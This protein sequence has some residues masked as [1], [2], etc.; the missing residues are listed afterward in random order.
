M[1]K[2]QSLIFLAVIMLLM[3]CRVY[4]SGIVQSEQNVRVE[5]PNGIV[6]LSV[7]DDG[8]IRTQVFKGDELESRWNPAVIA[9]PLPLSQF[10][11]KESEKEVI[12][13]TKK[14]KV[15]VNKE[16]S[17]I[18]YYN[19]KGDLLTQTPT[20]G[21][22]T[23]EQD[24]DGGVSQQFLV[25][26][27]E[28]LYGVGQYVNGLPY[29]NGT[30]CTLVQ[31]NMEDAGHVIMSDRGYGMFWNNP[32]AGEFE[33]FGNHELL[34][35]KY[36]KTEDGQPGFQAYF[37]PEDSKYKTDHQGKMVKTK[38]SKTIDVSADNSIINVMKSD[39]DEIARSADNVKGENKK[40]ATLL[41]KGTLTTPDRT[42][43]YYFNIGNS[44]RGVRFVVDG[45]RVVE[46]RI[47]HGY[48]WN[49]GR[50]WLEANTEYPFELYYSHFS[51][52]IS[53]QLYWDP[54]ADIYKQY[55]WKSD[56]WK[57]VDYF[58]FADDDYSGIMNK[59]YA[60]T[61]KPSIIPKWSL[62]YIHCQAIPFWTDHVNGFKREGFLSLAKYYRE[63]Q[64]PCDV[65]VQDFMWWT[66]MGSH[67]FRPDCYPD[68]KSR[69]KE[70]HDQ[71]F[72]YMISV[73]PL[74]QASPGSG[75]QEELTEA[76]LK[77]R[78]ELI[79]KGLMIGDS[80]VNYVKKEARE[81]AWRQ[82]EE[83]LYN[84]DLRVDAFWLD[85]DEGGAKDP[86]Y[87]NAYPLLSK[88]S[89]HDG[90]KAAYPDTRTFLMGRSMFPG[91]QRYDMAMWSGDIGNDFWTIE[92]QISA[93]LSVSVCGIPYWTTDIGGFGGGFKRD[94][95]YA[96]GKDDATDP[97]FREVV[98][99]WFQYG[100]FCPIFRLHRADNNAAPWFYG[101]EVEGIIANT[102]RFRYRLM[103][104][105]YSMTKRTR[106]EGY[107]PMRPL[108]M[109]FGED[110]NIRDI[111]KQFMYG[112]AFLVCP[113]TK[114]LYNPYHPDSTKKEEL[115]KTELQ[116]WDLYLPKG[117]DWYDFKTGEKFEG[118]QTISAPAPLDWM[119][120]YVKAGS[121]VPMGKVIQ[122]TTSEKQTE[123]E[124]R[125][126]PGK[127]VD[128]V[129]YD[130]D[131]VSYQYE[132]GAYSEIAIHWNDSKQEL[133][134][135]DRKGSYEGM[136]EK[137]ILKPVIV[138]KDYGT[139]SLAE[140]D[141]DIQIEYTGKSVSWKK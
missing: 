73:W 106:E 23:I 75:Y 9:E 88:M 78:N 130:D 136:P 132:K 12:L 35:D 135:G 39:F 112:D 50:K 4:A 42:G 30:G 31:T 133:T 69:L 8:I 85:A 17:Q 113:V 20:N 52:N 134:I 40:G 128:Y 105:V 139:G 116:Y 51:E 124:L 37:Y 83:T 119:P 87:T 68:I 81:V 93:G 76:D 36:V 58:V 107:N 65:L 56:R 122:N 45:E 55:T 91:S 10:S 131:G 98:A 110:E 62:G 3:T 13:E 96:N 95:E 121:I 79:D 24:K 114:G 32:S 90:A 33:A 67:I 2:Q 72:K 5:T 109:D 77:N 118:G 125:I 25:S 123:L 94:P 138:S 141:G 54:N 111:T 99:R 41:Y 100:M 70:V 127:D 28:H 108:F 84:D 57:T 92:R 7:Y 27:D 63:N 115:K 1:R 18:S 66:A 129:L 60:T 61:G 21:G 104:Y 46:R 26:K 22:F 74:Y 48:S 19:K 11:V 117:A 6:Q 38:I 43:W 89:F 44:G 59:L 49:C 14:M 16:T 82:I 140:Y 120:L 101:D 103:P 126:Y 71:N 102:I 97:V 34:S 29:V 64:V 86:N 53:L 47:P 80:W 137:L 15:I